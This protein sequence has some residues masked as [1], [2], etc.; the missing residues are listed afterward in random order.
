MAIID[1]GRS[2]IR[3]L[4]GDNPMVSS[5]PTLYKDAE[6][7]CLWRKSQLS[8]VLTNIVLHLFTEKIQ[9]PLR[10][11]RS[12]SKK[13]SLNTARLVLEGVTSSGCSVFEQKE[14]IPEMNLLPDLKI[15]V[16]NVANKIFG[17]E[18]GCISTALKVLKKDKACLTGDCGVYGALSIRALHLFSQLPADLRF[19]FF[20][21]KTR[22]LV[23]TYWKEKICTNR[24]YKTQ[25]ERE[26]EDP[27]LYIGPDGIA[28]YGVPH[29]ETAREVVL[30]C[31]KKYQF[32]GAYSKEHVSR[33]FEEN[34][35]WPIFGH[36]RTDVEMAMEEFSKNPGSFFSLDERKICLSQMCQQKALTCDEGS[37]NNIA[38]LIVYGC[39]GPISRQ[40]A[41]ARSRVSGILKDGG[42]VSEAKQALRSDLASI[43]WDGLGRGTLDLVF[44]EVVTTEASAAEV[45]PKSKRRF[46]SRKD[47]S[48]DVGA[49]C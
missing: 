42:M 24:V 49:M 33:L 15:R 41:E 40:Y 30:L 38:R 32:P 3:G 31:L 36:Q 34:N 5:F 17:E 10:S 21:P 6:S 14:G 45:T 43:S 29:I 9:E 18:M 47:S 25:V 7:K 8:R 23:C 37:C 48:P 27:E 12:C 19:Q 4:M 26:C 13:M 2:L 46:G 20:P 16:S 1:Q 35:V 44:K 28:V 11:M 22:R 39:D